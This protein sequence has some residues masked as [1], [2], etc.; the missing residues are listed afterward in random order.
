MR[1][2]TKELLQFINTEVPTKLKEYTKVYLTLIISRM[3]NEAKELF[4]K[5]DSFALIS[6]SAFNNKGIPKNHIATIQQILVNA[7]V[8]TINHS[9]QSVN[10]RSKFNGNAGYPKSYQINY[11]YLQT[12]IMIEAK[13]YIPTKKVQVTIPELKVY[14]ISINMMKF[15]LPIDEIY[16]KECNTNILGMEN[17]YYLLRKNLH[18][19]LNLWQF[20]N[21]KSYSRCEAGR[22]HNRITR[23]M[24]G[25]RKY[26]KG[27]DSM[28]MLDISN[29][30]MFL[31][32][33]L[34]KKDKIVNKQY[35]ELVCS[36]L[37]K[38]YIY[39]Q[40]QLSEKYNWY[41][42][43]KV[44]GDI[45]TYFFGQ[46]STHTFLKEI[47]ES[48]FKNVHE[49]LMEMKANDY[50]HSSFLLQQAEA[51]MM[52]DKVYSEAKKE[53]IKTCFIHDAII[54]PNE[55]EEK[56]IEIMLFEFM[57]EYDLTPNLKK[58]LFTTIK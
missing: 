15:K 53:G 58:G 7:G 29:C 21:I 46:S 10:S 36:G 35:N 44:K 28:V 19:Y 31:L 11:S 41:S 24:K 14:H 51:K 45:N 49:Y 12:P 40:Y 23:V 1:I 16:Q 42:L 8:I 32:A 38:E 37:Y 30:Q 9:Y 18:L 4:L 3:I 47:M 17:D 54:I 57:M 27:F 26:I 22:L 50:K 43:S 56:V 55:F 6:Y 13:K 48:Q 20:E 39:Q 34:M 52:I 5:N 25:L 33:C 2:F